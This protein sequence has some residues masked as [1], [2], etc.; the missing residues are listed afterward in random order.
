MRLLDRLIKV[1][2]SFFSNFILFK[3][4]FNLG[5]HHFKIINVTL[6]DMGMY[7]CQIRAG[8]R[9]AGSMSRKAKLTILRMFNKSNIQKKKN[10]FFS[11]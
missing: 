7:Q 9:R 3:I 5:E 10:L 8:P 2:L 1:I 6:E 4:K 11:K